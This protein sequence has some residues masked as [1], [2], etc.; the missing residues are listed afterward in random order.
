MGRLKRLIYGLCGVILMAGGSLRLLDIFM[1][2]ERLTDIPPQVW[3]GLSV[4]L[5]GV[6]LAVGFILFVQAVFSRRR[7][8]GLTREQEGGGI[9]VSE[10]ALRACVHATLTRYPYLREG[11]LRMHVKSVHGAIVYD[12]RV[13]LG[14]HN[15]SQR[16]G[17]RSTLSRWMRWASKS[18]TASPTT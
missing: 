2:V 5:A 18:A 6:C 14:V 8:H 4:S 13:W 9:Y 11:R 3:K 16:C 7:I 15:G 12:L 10:K 17:W 1:P